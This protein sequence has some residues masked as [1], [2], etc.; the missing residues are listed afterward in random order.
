MILAAA[1]IIPKQGDIN[2]NLNEHYKFIKL[3][4]E[5]KVELISFPELSITSYDRENAEN[6]AF[7]PNDSR[8]NQLEKLAQEF[9]I[10]IIAGAPVKV[11]GNLYIGSFVIMPNNQTEIYTKQFL[12]TGEELFYQ[13]SFNYNPQIRL[14]SEKLSLAICADIDHPEHAGNAC[15]SGS[16]IYLPSIF[17]SKNGI[18]EAYSNLSTYAKRHSMNILMSNFGGKV[19]NTEA[20]GKSAFWN[21]EGRLIGTIDHDQSGL[22]LVKKG[23]NN[24][25]GKVINC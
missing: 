19:W 21:T 2:Y 23:G 20:A 10:V 17:F 11:D 3:A 22:L 24:W 15:N 25:E 1:Q 7:T 9:N 12:H 18:P 13:S 16:T 4:V 8:L 5:N 6:L 14:G